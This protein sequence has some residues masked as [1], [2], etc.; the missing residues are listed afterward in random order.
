VSGNAPPPDAGETAA[1]AMAFLAN[2][3]AVIIDLRE[4]GGGTPSMVDLLM[5]YLY[6]RGA[7]VHLNDFR[8][9][10]SVERD[11]F[12]TLPWVPGKT[13]A[14]KPV[15]VTTRSPTPIGKALA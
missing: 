7:R 13:L 3:D 14:G 6:P 9:R 12:W 2:S 8:R 15:Y 11:Q 4:N 5:S 1:A 10:S